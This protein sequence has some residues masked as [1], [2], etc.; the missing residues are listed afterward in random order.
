MTIPPSRNP[1][2][3]SNEFNQLLDNLRR[4]ANAVLNKLFDLRSKSAIRR[5]QLLFILFLASGF[6]VNLRYNSIATWLNHIQNI[7]LYFFNPTYRATYVGDPISSM[8]LFAVSAAIDPRG[9]QYLPVFLASFFIALQCAAAYLADIF[10]LDDLS[11]ARKFI[12]GVALSG[13][14]DKIRFSEGYIAEKN[15]QSPVYLIGG[16]G[17]VVV[18]LDTAVLFEKSDGTPH[19]IGP[20]GSISGGSEQLDGFERFRAAIN[21]RDR[22]SLLQD[23]DK[24]ERNIKSRSLDGIRV[25]AVDVQVISSIFRDG[26][27]PSDEFPFPF[28]EK[29]FRQWVYEWPSRVARDSDRPSIHTFTSEAIPPSIIRGELIKFISTR[30]LTE[31]FASIGASEI[32]QA[33]AR[34]SEISKVA[35]RVTPPYEDIPKPEA[36]GQA[37]PF[38]T[39]SSLSS[40]FNDFEARFNKDAKKRGVQFRWTGVGAWKTIEMV[41]A[42]HIDAWQKFKEN[43]GQGSKN[44]I[45]NK[46]VEAG[47]SKIVAMIQDVPITH[48]DVTN[49]A[50]DRPTAIQLLL[51]EYRRQL[52]D[53]DE[54]SRKNFRRIPPT[55][56]VALAYLSQ[57]FRPARMVQRAPAPPKTEKE[58]ELYE[59]LVKKIGECNGVPLSYVIES[60]EEWERQFTPNT[61]REQILE[62]INQDWDLAM[63][64][65]WNS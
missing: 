54:F 34:V 23:M 50:S 13:S 22:Y 29:S 65:E 5:G 56:V 4:L 51:E 9:L 58:K 33:K 35:H 44:S 8:L 7:F 17:K 45:V 41:P 57:L 43:L 38:T 53:V 24:P 36:V 2:N 28:S 49:S 48:L 20:T 42:R 32:D 30:K 19:V 14:N 59:M 63:T 11:V 40:L 47:L 6:A 46:S 16:P 1:S 25:T 21:L 62:K 15:R 12:W 39:R 55:L 52:K 37:P 31:F 26:K 60:L 64:G 61:S 10:E 3:F 27:A 18:D